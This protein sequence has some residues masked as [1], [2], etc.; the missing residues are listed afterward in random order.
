MAACV[1]GAGGGIMGNQEISSDSGNQMVASVS[2]SGGGIMTQN[3][4]KYPFQTKAQIKA[5]LTSD[6]DYAL[7]CLVRLYN[8]QTEYEQEK[9]TTVNKNRRGFASSH[10][11]NGSKLAVKVISGEP[12]T[13]EETAQACEIASHYSK[14][15][16]A[17][18]RETACEEN[19]ELAESAAV[20]FAPQS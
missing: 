19:P 18:S 17:V 4:N 13:D 3:T 8:L 11:V 12:M 5:R 20:F 1:F 15:L 14:Q 16:A 6:K 7:S 10:A 2:A 9:Q